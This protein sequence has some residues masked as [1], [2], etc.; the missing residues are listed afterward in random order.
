MQ[1]AALVE[2]DKNK[3]HRGEHTRIRNYTSFRVVRSSIVKHHRLEKC[4]FK[5][6]ALQTAWIPEGGSP[7]LGTLSKQPRTATATCA[8]Q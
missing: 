8:K 7:I 3:N 6:F 2:F 4:A 5:I 1:M